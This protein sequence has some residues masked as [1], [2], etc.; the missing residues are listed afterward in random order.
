MDLTNGLVT[1][2]VHFVMQADKKNQLIVLVYLKYYPARKVSRH[3]R[4]LRLELN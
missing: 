3:L 2:T 1:V 4:D